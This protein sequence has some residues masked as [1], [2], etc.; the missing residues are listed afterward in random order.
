MRVYQ[1]LRVDL[2][3]RFGCG[4]HVARRE[5]GLDAIALA[6]QQAAAFEQAGLR[7]LFA[8]GRGNLRRDLNSGH[9]AVPRRSDGVVECRA[10]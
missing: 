3:M 5:D 6:Q 2:E 1:R 8:N 7:G 9:D 10:R 4:V